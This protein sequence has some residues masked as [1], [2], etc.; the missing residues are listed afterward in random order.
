M[1]VRHFGIPVGPDIGNVRFIITGGPLNIGQAGRGP[2]GVAADHFYHEPGLLR[3]EFIEFQYRSYGLLNRNYGW[4]EHFFRSSGTG[5]KLYRPDLFVV[6]MIFVMQ[7]APGVVFWSFGN[8]FAAGNGFAKRY[9]S[10]EKAKEKEKNAILSAG[11]SH[12][13]DLGNT[14][15]NQRY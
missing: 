8:R 3:A 6:N 9:A 12:L 14:Q 1:K 11:K 4:R 5:I 15:F 2:V 7:G 10:G 13:T